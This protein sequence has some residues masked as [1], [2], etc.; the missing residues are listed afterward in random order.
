MGEVTSGLLRDKSTTL[1]LQVYVRHPNRS[2]LS[3]RMLLMRQMRDDLKV[4]RGQTK[5]NQ[6]FCLSSILKKVAVKKRLRVG[7]LNDRGIGFA[8]ADTYVLD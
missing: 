8:E 3:A 7:G 1:V 5:E 6:E 2:W 4:E